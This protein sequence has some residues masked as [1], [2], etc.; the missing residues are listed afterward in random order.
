MFQFGFPRQ[1]AIG[2]QAIEDNGG[3][4][5]AGDLPDLDRVA[6]FDLGIGPDQSVDLD[7]LFFVALAQGPGDPACRLFFAGDFNEIPQDGA[8]G[9]DIFRVQASP[10]LA[11]I[12]GQSFADF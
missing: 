7:V 12:I 1:G 9:L 8:Q 3:G 6:H 5:L 10:T 11:D 2:L 4:G